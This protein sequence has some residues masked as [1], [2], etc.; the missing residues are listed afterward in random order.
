MDWWRVGSVCSVLARDHVTKRPVFES[1]SLHFNHCVIFLSKVFTPTG[2]CRVSLS[3]LLARQIV[4][5]IRLC[6]WLENRICRLAGKTAI[7]TRRDFPRELCSRQTALVWNQALVTWLGDLQS[8][9][10]G[11]FRS[12]S[13]HS[14][15]CDVECSAGAM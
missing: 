7:H 1:L 3:T 6:L 2:T 5:Q 10:L 15:F 12:W 14:A 4:Y 9:C 13:S 11:I 8:L